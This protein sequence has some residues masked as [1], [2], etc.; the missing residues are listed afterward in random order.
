[1]ALLVV[2]DVVL[3]FVL[4]VTVPTVAL[5]VAERAVD[6][7]V[8]PVSAAAVTATVIATALRLFPCV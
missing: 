7:E 3:L 4:G 5:D 6:A 2:A 1:M 8:Q